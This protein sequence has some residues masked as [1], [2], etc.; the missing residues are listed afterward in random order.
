M[1]VEEG[2]HREL[3]RLAQDLVYDELRP[4]KAVSLAS[5]L[6][7]EGRGGSATVALASQPA[8]L[9]LLDVGEVAPLV[10][11][12]L[13]ELG[14]ALPSPSAA[15]WASARAVADSMLHGSVAPADGAL[16]LWWLWDEC[17]RRAGD[18]LTEMLQL[19][20]RWEASVAE[21]RR[22]IEIEMV[23][24]AATVRSYADQ[25]IATAE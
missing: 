3:E 25:M 21:A 15:G 12:M 23:E 11:A 13:D 14:V 24:Y 5:N 20:D 17:G 2:R 10:R 18:P 6:V 8:S 16:R 9:R 1:S 19:H 7:A 22:E 4:E